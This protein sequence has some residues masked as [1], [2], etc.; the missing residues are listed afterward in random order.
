MPYLMYHSGLR[1][2]TGRQAPLWSR[3]VAAAAW[4]V[5]A[6]ASLIAGVRAANCGPIPSKGAT[7]QHETRQS[8]QSARPILPGHQVQ[9]SAVI[10]AGFCGHNNSTHA[11]GAE[12]GTT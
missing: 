11:S 4:A 7:G 8:G 6:K 1:A 12:A 5:N 10:M 9:L 3:G 2:I